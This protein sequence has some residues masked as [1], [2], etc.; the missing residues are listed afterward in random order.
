LD[1]AAINADGTGSGYGNVGLPIRHRPRRRSAPGER[2][3]AVR[4]RSKFGPSA[5]QRHPG[6]APSQTAG[7]LTCP[8]A[9]GAGS[10]WSGPGRPVL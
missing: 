3:A 8:A 6:E 10:G 1:S 9:A 5:R 4:G 7:S 2:W